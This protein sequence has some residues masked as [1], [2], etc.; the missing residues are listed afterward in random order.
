MAKPMSLMLGLVIAFGVGIVTQALSPHKTIPGESTPINPPENPEETSASV[1]SPEA[2]ESY[3]RQIT[4]KVLAGENSGSGVLVRRAGQ[5]YEVLTNNHVLL[6]GRSPGK[7][8]VQTPDGRRYP[9]QEVRPNPFGKRDL[10]LLR[11]SSGQTYPIATLSRHFLPS[12]ND[13]VYALGYPYEN[14][15][16]STPALAFV[17]GKVALLTPM[18]FRGGYQIGATNSIV[19]GLSGGPL[20]NQ[21]REIIGI[22]GRRKYPSWGNPYIFDDNSLATPAEKARMQ[23]YSWFIPVNFVVQGLGTV[24]QNA[25][26]NLI[27]P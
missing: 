21:K 11:F 26:N 19:Q 5:T 2:I 15:D 25:N 10:G 8:Q 20:F 9:A 18:T 4:V 12:I 3:G 23:H 22:T 14:Q 13:P 17:A 1:Y 24:S 6:F 27:T 16:K 7:F